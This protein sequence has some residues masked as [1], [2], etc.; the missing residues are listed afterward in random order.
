MLRHTQGFSPVMIRDEQIALM[1]GAG[2][3]ALLLGALGFQYLAHLPPCEMCHWQR[4][5]HIAAALI[6]FGGA[7]LWKGD[8]RLFTIPVILLIPLLG[9][10]VAKQNDMAPYIAIV[11]LVL[12][13]FAALKGD[14]RHL[15]MVTVVLLVISGLVGAYQ[16]ALQHGLVPLPPCSVVHPYVVGSGAADPAVSC[17][18]VTWS[19]FGLSLAAYNVIFSF[20]IAATAAFLLS[21]KH[22]A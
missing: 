3:L 15:T 16:T 4:W 17:N 9:I 5:P 6:G 20:V 1:V 18:A 2:G 21:R 19:L 10:L 22:A 11:A 14:T 13:G 12:A 8:K 7:H